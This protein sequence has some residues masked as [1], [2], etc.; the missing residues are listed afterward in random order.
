MPP[1]FTESPGGLEFSAVRQERALSS[2]FR[3]FSSRHLDK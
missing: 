2:S 3:M 1:L